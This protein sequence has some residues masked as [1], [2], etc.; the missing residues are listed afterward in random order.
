MAYT[1][2]KTNDFLI[3]LFYIIDENNA[4]EDYVTYIKVETSLPS[5]TTNETLTFEINFDSDKKTWNISNQDDSQYGLSSL[6]LVEWFNKLV[7]INVIE[8]VETDKI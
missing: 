2:E 4:D 8:Y 1:N 5:L 3:T 7:E 6:K